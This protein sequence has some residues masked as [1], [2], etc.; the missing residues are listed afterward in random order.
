M[1]DLFET[2]SQS[3]AE[4]PKLKTRNWLNAL[5]LMRIPFSIFL[6]PVFWF[7][8]INIQVDVS[9][10]ILAF[11]AIHLFLYPASNGYNSYFDRDEQSIGGLKNPPKVTKELWY[12]ILLFDFLSILFATFVSV[13]FAFMAFI[14]L[15]ISKA[16]SYD[17]IRLKKFPIIGALTVVF[18][19]GFWTY[20]MVQVGVSASSEIFYR[21]NFLLAVVSS[22]FLLGSYPITQIYQHDEDSKHGDR[23][24]S[25]FLGVNG[26]FLFSSL[27]FLLA[28][29][30][31]I[32]VFLEA[33]YFNFVI[34]YLIA[35]LPVNIYFFNWYNDYRKGKPVITFERMMKLNV[36]SS[37]LLSSA[38][39]V[40]L[41]LK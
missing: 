30:L 8:L 9:K 29:V 7:A 40:M 3:P 41:I 4:N 35:M 10:A 25:L 2:R 5:Q 12:L 16:Y 1:A 38:F 15:I 34:I 17:K 23:S 36:M 28:S 24:L 13:A 21:E 31:L 22:L 26:T 39:I 27:A 14:Y 37:L 19:Q 20:M 18:F 11:I 6:M 33:L 32:Y